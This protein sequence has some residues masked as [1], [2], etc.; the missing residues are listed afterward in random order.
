[1]KPT[2]KLAECTPFEGREHRYQ[3]AAVE[4]YY[5]ETAQVPATWEW[6]ATTCDTRCLNHEHMVLRAP[7]TIKYP[8]NVCVYCGRSAYT[9][10]HLIPK[11]WSGGAKR[12]F[13]ATV[14]A[15]GTCNSL[16]ADAL[17]WSITERRALCKYRL[18]R[19]FIK[20]LRTV[21]RTPD[22]LREYGPTLRR[23]IRAAM[24]SKRE[25]ERMLAWPDD[26]RF[27]ER[28]LERTGFEDPYALG[29]IISD[30]DANAA[31]RKFINESEGRESV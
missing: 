5:I 28:A 19:K 4:K 10:D 15:C 29:L 30:A 31:V 12:G 14:P 1:M 21:D 9:V 23:E 24:E 11:P 16:L 27:D 7:K 18:R 3:A 25:V 13:V 2:H 17:T 26:P 20:V 6:V 8:A 22:E